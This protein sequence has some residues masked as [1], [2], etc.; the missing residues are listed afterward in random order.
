MDIV[1]SKGE[2]TATQILEKMKG[3]PSNS[4]VRTHLRILEDK[5]FLKHR[6]EGVRFVFSPIEARE[7]ASRSALK[8][9]IH[10]FFDGSLTHAVAAL[11]DVG[12]GK[13]TPE[14]L[15]HLDSIV[16]AAKAKTK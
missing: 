11:V 16:K 7:T 2:A 14:E 13:L 15:N 12:S 8:R 1:F 4:A 10:T 9:L 5:G 3:S 6:Q